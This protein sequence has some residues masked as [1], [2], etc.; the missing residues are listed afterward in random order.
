[1]DPTGPDT[2]NNWKANHKIVVNGLDIEKNLIT[3]TP[4]MRNESPW[5]VTLLNRA[6][7]EIEKGNP[8]V[9]RFPIPSNVELKEPWVALVQVDPDKP[10][11]L[12]PLFEEIITRKVV[13]RLYYECS[14]DTTK[15]P[16][17]VYQLWVSWSKYVVYGVDF[18]VKTH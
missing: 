8:M 12:W 7:Q 2:D 15:L 4:G 14:I 16:E 9:T 18:S 10:K 1:V 11:K 3:G 13:D 6:P 17:G 5:L